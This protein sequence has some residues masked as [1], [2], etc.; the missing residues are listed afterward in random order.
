C[1]PGRRRHSARPTPPR[2]LDPPRPP[3]KAGELLPQPPCSAAARRSG[4]GTERRA[5]R[6]GGSGRAPNDPDLSNRAEWNHYIEATAAS[7]AYILVGMKG[8]EG[9]APVLGPGAEAHPALAAGPHP[10]ETGRG[11][12]DAHDAPQA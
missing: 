10:R 12:G 8:G 6:L 3:P 11:A 4:G 1:E 2:S 7:R 9:I 5:E